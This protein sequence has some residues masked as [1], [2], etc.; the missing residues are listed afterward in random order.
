MKGTEQRPRPRWLTTKFINKIS[1]EEVNGREI[2]NIVRVAHALAINDKR[3]MKASDILQGLQSLKNFERDFN[4]A[5]IAKRKQSFKEQ[6]MPS[7][8]AKTNDED[9]FDEASGTVLERTNQ[10]SPWW[11]FWS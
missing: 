10:R 6:S 2:K 7:K 9:E 1:E 11:K 3:E 5:G 8:K 4:E